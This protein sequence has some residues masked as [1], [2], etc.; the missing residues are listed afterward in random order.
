M[1]NALRFSF[2]LQQT[3][4]IYTRN[5]SNCVP[6][7]YHNESNNRKFS[8]NFNDERQ[9]ND[10]KYNWSSDVTLKIAALGLIS[11]TAYNWHK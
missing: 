10:Q 3:K 5:W 8:T 2:V 11:V 7:A 9:K 1:S 6:L 4:S